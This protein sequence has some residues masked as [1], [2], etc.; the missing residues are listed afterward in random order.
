MT[1]T[2]PTRFTLRRLPLAAK[3]VLTVFLTAVGLGY[4]SALVQLHLKHSGKEGEALPTVADVVERF[5]GVKAPDPDAP[6]PVCR[7]RQL[8]S[9]N[10]DD[11]DVG[12]E[13]MAPAFFAKSKGYKAECEARGKAAVDPERE[14]EL[15]AVME[16]CKAD[17]PARKAAYDADNFPLPADRKGKAITAQFADPG[18]SAVKIR[19]LIDTR[20]QHCHKD[21]SPS[22]GTY[23][24]LEPLV[25]P[26]SQELIDGKW[27]RSG[28]QISVEA[29]TQSTHAHLLSFAVLFTL[30]GLVFAFTGYP[31]VIRGV[32]APVVLVAQVAD[33][34]CWW[35]ARVP[36]YGPYFA[37]AIVLTGGVV[38]TGLMLQIVLGLLDLYGRVGKLVLVLL[39]LAAAAGF[40]VLGVKVIKP[41]LD[42][43]R[44]SV[45]KAKE[46]G[47]QREQAK[48]TQTGDG[49]AAA[50]ESQLERLVMGPLQGAP[51]KGT[52]SMAAAF[53]HKDGADY[54]KE[55]KARGKAVVDAEREGE[56]QAVRAWIK[57]DP[58][59]R[60]AAY[61]ADKFPL[62]PDLAGKPITADYRD[63]GGAAKVKS[64]LTDRCARCHAAGGEQE[65]HPLD[66]YDALAKYIDGGK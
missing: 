48:P 3:L 44:D 13:N 33:V 2:A 61:E 8:L 53:F 51:W 60:K 16:W 14:G 56:R 15:L 11:A 41:A 12:K 46:E 29:L 52:G 62:P 35:L 26:P 22:L 31:A 19:T 21:Q 43:E 45:V 10:R 30:T 40:G 47:Q 9:G 59:A 24:D 63:D 5:A 32:V 1:D 38:G 18:K 42:A 39:F 4:F 17:P 27:V 25:T 64:I 20:C 34:S 57:A 65:E 28:K 37:Q 7:V 49:Q 54:N 36:G 23:A 50:K 66:S 6:P 55:V 58:A